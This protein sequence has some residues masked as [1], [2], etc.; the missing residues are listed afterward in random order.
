MCSLGE[1]R[2]A[3]NAMFALVNVVLVTYERGWPGDGRGD[4]GESLTR[5]HQGIPRIS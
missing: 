1:G 2:G 5:H 3:V 4:D